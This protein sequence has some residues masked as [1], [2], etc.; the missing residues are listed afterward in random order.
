MTVTLLDLGCAVDLRDLGAALEERRIFAEPHGAAEIAARPALLEHVAT[1]PLG[2]QTDHD[3]F[4]RTELGR[5]C[6]F[7]TDKIARR[8]DHRHLQSKA[9]AK[10]RHLTRTRKLHRLD[11]ALR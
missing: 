3:V 11:F 8:L 4:A 7:K 2:H 1:H 5:A 9:N 6:A 10:E